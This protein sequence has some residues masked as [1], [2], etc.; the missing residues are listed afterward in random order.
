MI[1][2]TIKKAFPICE[3]NACL[4]E[5]SHYFETKIIDIENSKCKITLGQNF[6]FLAKNPNQ[7]ELYFLAFDKCVL[8]DN[9]NIGKGRADF[10]LISNSEFSIIEIKDTF[11][12]RNAH[13]TTV[14]K[15][16]E[17]TL[18]YFIENQAILESQ[19]RI[20]I[21]CWS[22]K[23]TRPA[24]TSKQNSY[25]YFFDLYNAELL[26]GNSKIYK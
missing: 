3:T 5:I 25:K 2:Q 20:L 10:A 6:H 12:N 21:Q 8:F 1:A 4:Q 11:R 26:E 14:N 22:Y 18:I 24:S 15:Q 13:K 16:L 9:D 17:D 19:K 23:P 7:I